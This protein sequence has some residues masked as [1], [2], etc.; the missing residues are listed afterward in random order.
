MVHRQLPVI[1]PLLFCKVVIGEGLLQQQISGVCIIP[2]DTH[3]TGLTPGIA[4]SADPAFLV[5]HLDILQILRRTDILFIKEGGLR[6]SINE[7]LIQKNI[8]K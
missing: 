7:L 8:T 1:L 2:R 5:Q 4:V 3:E 6:M